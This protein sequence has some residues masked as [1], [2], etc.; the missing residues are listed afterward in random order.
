[1]ADGTAVLEIKAEDQTAEGFSKVEKSAQGLMLKLASILAIG[2]LIKSSLSSFAV[3]EEAEARLTFL[4][5]KRLG[6]TQ[7]QVQA[8]KE[9][10]SAIQAQGV[11][12]DELLI[13][14]QATLANYVSQ[15]ETLALLAKP[16]ADLLAYSDGLT[17][18]VGSAEALAQTLGRAIQQNNAELLKRQGFSITQ[19][20]IDRFKELTT[21]EEKAAMLAALIEKNVGGFNAMLRQTDAGKLKDLNNT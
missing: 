13:T 21:E 8:I 1:M 12:G 16:F 4:G 2:A 6:L 5:Q 7:S 3:Q 17:A 15:K 14:G 20:E 10:S 19:E 18:S 11:I 9:Q